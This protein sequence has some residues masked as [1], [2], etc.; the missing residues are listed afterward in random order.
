MKLASVSPAQSSHWTLESLLSN[1]EILQAQQ[2]SSNGGAAAAGAFAMQQPPPQQQR[3]PPPPAAAAAA[4]PQ[5]LPFGFDFRGSS[6][7][8]LGSRRLA[9]LSAPKFAD[10]RPFHAN[11]HQ[12]WIHP[13]SFLLF[14]FESVCVVCTFLAFFAVSGFT[15]SSLISHPLFSSPSLRSGEWMNCTL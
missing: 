15:S 5:Q 2:F 3:M 13:D 11:G 10:L 12:V 7:G 9:T 1:K 6:P 8:G 14:S 4:S